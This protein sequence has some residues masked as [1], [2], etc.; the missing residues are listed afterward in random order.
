MNMREKYWMEVKN[1][2]LR[3]DC[4]LAAE[5]VMAVLTCNVEQALILYKKA[6]DVK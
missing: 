4:K 6:V 1:A 2:I 5:M 3:K